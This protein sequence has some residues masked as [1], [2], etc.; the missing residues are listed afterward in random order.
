MSRGGWGTI[1]PRRREFFD[2]IGPDQPQEP[3]HSTLG[4]SQST[5]SSGDAPQSRSVR[6]SVQASGSDGS[7]T[8]GAFQCAVKIKRLLSHTNRGDRWR[9][10]ASRQADTA[11][12]V[13]Y[14][15]FP[16]PGGIHTMSRLIS[17]RAIFSSFS[18]LRSSSSSFRTSCL[19]AGSNRM[20]G[21]LP[22]ENVGEPGTGLHNRIH[23]PRGGGA[24][25]D[26]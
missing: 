18:K 13:V 3:S 2:L 17:P 25:V 6:L 8:T 5:V 10:R 11:Q 12:S 16:E 26:G 23:A 1:F 9:S 7:C 22:W 14:T 4:V 15:D 21:S 19:F 20:G 24:R